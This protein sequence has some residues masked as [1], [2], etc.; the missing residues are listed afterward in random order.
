MGDFLSDLGSSLSDMFSGGGQQFSLPNVEFGSNAAQVANDFGGL[1]FSAGDSGFNPSMP[2]V[3]DFSGFGD[4]YNK[5]NGFFSGENGS[6]MKNLIGAAGTLYNLN[7][8]RRASNQYRGAVNQQAQ[9]LND[10][11]SVNSPYAQQMERE[12]ARRDAAAGRR[13]QYGSRSVELQAKLAQAAAQARAQ[14]LNA[15]A[16]APMYQASQST[17][18]AT[19]AATGEIANALPGLLKMFSSSAPQ[20][21]MPNLSFGTGGSGGLDLS[22]IYQ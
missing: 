16:S 13:S 11:F 6:N 10:M 15:T 5:V 12:L 14:S 1:N 19:F 20:F 2:T 4:L 17:L 22:G 7:A 18:P 21:S 9:S 8:Q 3:P